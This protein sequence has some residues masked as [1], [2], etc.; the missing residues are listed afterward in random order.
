MCVAHALL[1]EKGH[2]TLMTCTT[3]Y[4]LYF[5]PSMIFFQRPLHSKVTCARGGPVLL[6]NLPF[7]FIL[8]LFYLIPL[9]FT[10]NYPKTTK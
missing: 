9:I 5:Q 6:P 10:P 7:F 4:D 2:R 8:S 1:C 3:V